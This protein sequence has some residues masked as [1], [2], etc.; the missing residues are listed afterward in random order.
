MALSVLNG[1]VMLAD[2]NFTYVVLITKLNK[3]ITMLL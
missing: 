1:G 2:L 3:P